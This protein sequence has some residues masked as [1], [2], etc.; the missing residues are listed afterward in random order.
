[1]AEKKN[2]KV[3]PVHSVNPRGA[4]NDPPFDKATERR[5]NQL[6]DESGQGNTNLPEGTVSSGAKAG[7]VKQPGVK[8]DTP[9][10]G[11]VSFNMDMYQL[12]ELYANLRDGNYWSA[13]KIA[14][15]ILH[16]N[17]NFDAKAV[18]GTP[19]Q[20]F[21][22]KARQVPV[23]KTQVAETKEKLEECCAD[24][25]KQHGQQLKTSAKP[26]AVNASMEKNVGKVDLQGLIALVRMI[27][28]L[29]Q[30]E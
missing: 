20:R 29:F 23:N 4:E 28:G 19:A 27:L 25:E 3:T 2:D 14:V 13:M 22:A 16:S 5:D 1:M 10:E 26:A 8:T 17:M 6:P 15:E 12:S 21:A 9:D 24:L 30:S 7:T 18:R 11:F